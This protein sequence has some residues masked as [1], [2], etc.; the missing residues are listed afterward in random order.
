MNYEKKNLIIA[1]FIGASFL[2]LFFIVIFSQKRGVPLFPEKEPPTSP[3]FG[4]LPT[5]EI[6]SIL[7]ELVPDGRFENAISQSEIAALP[8]TAPVYAFS[9]TEFLNPEK[10]KTVALQLGLSP[11]SERLLDGTLLWADENYN[12]NYDHKNQ[13]FILASLEPHT[14]G[15]APSVEEAITTVRQFLAQT[16]L[17]FDDI[18]I[19]REE[20]S[21]VYISPE[22]VET[23]PHPEQGFNAVRVPVVRNLPLE[24]VSKPSDDY[25]I[26]FFVGSGGKI[27]NAKFIYWQLD[28]SQKGIYKLKDFNTAW[29]EVLAGKAEFVDFGKRSADIFFE[30]LKIERVKLLSVSLASF[31]S[32]EREFFLQ[33]VYVLKG[34]ATLSD[35]GT[36]EV[37]LYLPA[38]ESR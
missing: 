21:L 28:Q 20:V 12:L 6:P 24:V 11:L 32:R 7:K 9:P 14:A 25:L 22:S 26:E 29:Q 23:A 37:T 3:I 18:K 35:G 33:P 17:N 31:E 16:G 4:E 30:D 5:P 1:L 15:T 34:Q 13:L 27:I 36:T 10:I 2:I 38:V 8:K 19:S